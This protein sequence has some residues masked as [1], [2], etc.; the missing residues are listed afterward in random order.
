VLTFPPLGQGTIDF[1]NLLDTLAQVG[2][3]GPFSAEIEIKG[4]SDAEEDAV[5]VHSRRYMEELL[6]TIPAR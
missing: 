3:R 1:K 4:L 5:R 6:G 2:Y